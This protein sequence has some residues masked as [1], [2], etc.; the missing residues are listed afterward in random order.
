MPIPLLKNLILKNYGVI[1]RGFKPY[2]LIFLFLLLPLSAHAEPYKILAFG[3]SL[4]A[5]YGLDQGQA[6]PDKLEKK[7]RAMGYDV[8]IVNAGVSGETT[9]G[10]LNRLDWTMKHN[11]DLVMLALGANDALRFIDPGL[12]KKNLDQMISKIKAYDAD[13]FL[14]GML[15]PRNI[16]EDFIKRFDTIYPDLAKEY[17]I[18]LYPFILEGVATNPDLNLKDGLH[19]N[20]KGTE[21][22]AD[23][24]LPYLRDILDSQ[25]IKQN[26]NEGK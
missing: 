19:P 3:D 23:R 1:F 6:Y 18:P 5:G 14:L 12:T 11:P 7:L 9:T 10:G 24:I 26:F 8:E 17:D 21:I 22:I 13:V 2:V 16:G 25:Q 4:T 20:N 15:A